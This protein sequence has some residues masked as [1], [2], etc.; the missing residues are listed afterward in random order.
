M[1]LV[2]LVTV[3]NV[4]MQLELEHSTNFPRL[5]Q[6]LEHFWAAIRFGHGKV[7]SHPVASTTH[8]LSLVIVM[9]PLRVGY[10]VLPSNHE[11]Q[12][13]AC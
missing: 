4:F 9:A 1:P 6:E 13:C 2:S 8:S 3:V 11:Q 7:T 5:H 12:C 10:G